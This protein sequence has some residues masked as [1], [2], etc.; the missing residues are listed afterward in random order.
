MLGWC[1][2]WIR[3]RTNIVFE[4]FADSFAGQRNVSCWASGWASDRSGIRLVRGLAVIALIL[5][6]A[7][8]TSDRAK[9]PRRTGGQP[10]VI[11]T[12]DLDRL[13][14]GR[15]RGRQDL[16]RAPHL[17]G[18]EAVRVGLLLPFS[19]PNQGVRQL[20]VALQDS[21]QMALFQSGVNN[22]LLLPKDTRGTAVG[23]RAAAEA[24]IESGAEVLLGP[25]F[26]ENV[27]AAAR[28]AVPYSVPIV[29]FSSDRTVAQPGVYL[30]SFQAEEEVRRV[31]QYAMSQGLLTFGALVPANSYG[32]LASDVLSQTV[33][34]NGGTVTNI[35]SYDTESKDFRPFAKKIAEYDQRAEALKQH[36]NELRLRN[37]DEAKNELAKLEK[38]ETFGA[39]SY[40]AVLIPAGGTT[41]RG[42]APLL[43]Y[44]DVDNRQVRFLGTGLWDDAALWREPA[45]SGGWFA[46]PSPD[47][48]EAFFS[49]FKSTFDYVPPRLAS[50]GFDAMMLT[51][52]LARG[53][54]RGERFTG[55]RLT[56]P[57]GF[58][59]V[60][61]VFR[62]RSDGSAERGL[63]VIEIRDG[64]TEVVSPAPQRF[65][66]T[67][68]Y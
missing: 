36:M 12:P 40:Q 49:M 48:R 26:A 38:Q 3:E 61:G 45:L 57:S 41:L 47:Q 54:P 1:V 50:L 30:L 39:V 5:G 7:A 63:A 34:R 33:F 66:G 20:S 44:F 35:V 56:N 60:D 15:G 18:Q 25:V 9:G 17:R 68:N 59:G 62:F 16:Y 6:V 28:I 14:D 31:T 4:N 27:N 51:A 65:D 58:A 37:D 42:L 24:A 11:G 55:E 13:P 64:K 43:P 8:C 2:L 53:M 46:A 32:E 67:S 29:A 52:A 23:A 19:S 10:F 22:V 21:V